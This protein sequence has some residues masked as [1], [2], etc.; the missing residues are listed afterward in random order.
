MG[1][2]QILMPKMVRTFEKDGYECRIYQA[3]FHEFH[4]IEIHLEKPNKTEVFHSPFP[5][6]G[7]ALEGDGIFCSK[8]EKKD[9]KQ[10]QQFF[11]PADV[12]FQFE[13]KGN[14]KVYLCGSW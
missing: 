1:D 13:N 3:E 7:I 14:F 10:W 12:E 6:V 2:P 11:I 5:F 4:C 9:V 8:D